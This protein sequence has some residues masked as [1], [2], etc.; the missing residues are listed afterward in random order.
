[1]FD[2]DLSNSS[3]MHSSTSLKSSIRRE[4]SSQSLKLN[5]KNP[6]SIR[7]NSSGTNLSSKDD[8]IVRPPSTPVDSRCQRDYS[9]TRNSLQ[10]ETCQL[11]GPQLCSDCI[12]IQTRS[13]LSPERLPNNLIRQ[14]LSSLAIRS[15]IPNEKSLTDDQ[16][17]QM[18]NNQQIQTMSKISNQLN[19]SV[20]SDQEYFHQLSSSFDQQQQQQ[21]PFFFQNLKDLQEKLR[22]NQYPRLFLSE[23]P[24]P[25]SSNQIFQEGSF[26]KF[27]ISKKYSSMKRASTTKPNL[28][29]NSITFISPRKSE[30]FYQ[31]NRFLSNYSPPLL[32]QNFQH[33]SNTFHSAQIQNKTFQR[34]LINQYSQNKTIQ[35]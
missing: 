7:R 33:N 26:S 12:E 6:F 17:F 9:S 23:N 1:M 21:T 27:D 31:E 14:R 30:L 5:S 15:L 16:L 25:R 29:T 19:N 2:N 20:L 11:L 24:P 34:S 4:K 3:D 32:N 18:I 13:N 8:L 10:R 28:Q 35:I 22:T